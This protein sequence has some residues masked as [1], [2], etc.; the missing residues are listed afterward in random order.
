MA[1]VY[2]VNDRVKEVSSNKE[3]TVSKNHV[4]GLKLSQG[5]C[6]TF[7]DPNYPEV[8]KN[9]KIY[10]GDKVNTDLIKL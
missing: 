9:Y 10:V 6:I 2:A 1:T 7:D 5:I 3:G 4:L 8:G